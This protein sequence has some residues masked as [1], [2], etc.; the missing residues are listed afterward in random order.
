VPEV[1]SRAHME[2]IVPVIS[3]ALLEAQQEVLSY[4]FS[5]PNEN[6]NIQITNDQLNENCKLENENYS[7]A[8]KYLQQNI[9]Y[10][11]VTAGPGLVGSLLVGF[12]AAKSIAYALGKPIVPV[13][14]IEGHIY[15]AFSREI[16]N[17]NVEI[18]N[19]SQNSNDKNQKKVSS[20][21]FGASNF[22]L[23]SLTVSGG[24]TSLTLMRDHGDYENIGQ[25]IDDAAGEAFDK[26]AKLLDLGYPGGPAVSKLA[27]QFRTA[28]R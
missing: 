9:D 26:V 13:N 7:A 28:S 15:S 17:P 16:R 5:V 24:H 12:N 23:I 11:A 3:Q 18:L 27:S 1:A 8:I 10:I 25:T 21:E 20:F 14:H 2:A 6:S 22:P 4:Q 19:K